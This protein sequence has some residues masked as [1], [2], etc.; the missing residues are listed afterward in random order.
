MAKKKTQV[1]PPKDAKP[2]APVGPKPPDKRDLLR[3]LQR[4]PYGSPRLAELKSRRDAA[5]QAYDDF[6]ATN[7]EY[8]R[9]EQV[10]GEAQEA[11]HELQRAEESTARKELEALRQR[12]HLRGATPALV[13]AI[14]EL[15]E[16]RKDGCET[17]YGY[18]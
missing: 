3:L 11:Y 18:Y 16:R 5:R 14:E 8:L 12:L 2:K 13:T 15:I 9:L 10:H 4:M 6:K 7:A 1:V 17:P